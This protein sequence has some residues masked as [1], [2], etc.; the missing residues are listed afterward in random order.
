[1][2]SLTSIKDFDQQTNKN[3]KLKSKRMIQ[4]LKKYM[5]QPISAINKAELLKF[6]YMIPD[7]DYRS[8]MMGEI[9][10]YVKY[11]DKKEQHKLFLQ[12]IPNKSLASHALV[13]F[14]KNP[15]NFSNLSQHQQFIQ[16]IDVYVDKISALRTFRNRLKKESGSQSLIK[17]I[18]DEIKQLKKLVKEHNLGDT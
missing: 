8:E 14:S 13:R 16:N 17:K 1:M 9:G 3:P 7:S 12:D 5:K 18:D 11:F 6:T 2:V 15:R 10:S 4:E